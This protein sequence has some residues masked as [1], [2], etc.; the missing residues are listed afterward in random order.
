MPTRRSPWMNQELDD[1]R[2]LAR[3]FSEK[4]IKPNIETFIK[5]KQV[6]RALWNKA[7]ELGLLCISIP[8]E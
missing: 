5:N 2:D 4:E 7:G 1:L 6:D 3:T 8:E